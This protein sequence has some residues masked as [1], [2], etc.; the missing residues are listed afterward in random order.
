[1]ICFCKYIKLISILFICQNQEQPEVAKAKAPS[2]AIAD[3]RSLEDL[4][5]GRD[6]ALI[7][8][9]LQREAQEA[10]EARKKEEEEKKKKGK[11]P[12]PV[13]AKPPGADKRLVVK[14]RKPI[15]A[16]ERPIAESPREE[17]EDVDVPAPRFV[18]SSPPLP[19]VAKMMSQG[20]NP[21]DAYK[22]EG[23]DNTQR[24][25]SPPLPGVAKLLAQ[26]INPADEYKEEE[27]EAQKK[28][29]GSGVIPKT[30]PPKAPA[31]QN[32]PKTQTPKSNTNVDFSKLQPGKDDELIRQILQ[33][34]AEAKAAAAK[35]AEEKAKREGK[36]EEA[37]VTGKPPL[38]PG[39]RGN[40]KVRM[41]KRLNKAIAARPPREPK[42][43]TWRSVHVETMPHRRA[44]G[45]QRRNHYLQDDAMPPPMNNKPSKYAAR[46]AEKPR[47][48]KQMHMIQEE[49]EDEED[50]E[51]PYFEPRRTRERTPDFEEDFEPR[52]PREMTP[53]FED[54]F[55]PRRPREM[56]PEFEE[57]FEQRRPGEMT[58]DFEDARPFRAIEDAEPMMPSR[59]EQFEEM[60]PEYFDDA[61]NYPVKEEA[62]PPRF[63]DMRGFQK[64]NKSNNAGVR[65][66]EPKNAKPSKRAPVKEDPARMIPNMR[67][68]NKY[69]ERFMRDEERPRIPAAVPREEDL[70]LPR[71]VST[72]P[73]VPAAAKREARIENEETTA[74]SSEEYQEAGAVGG[75][76]APEPKQQNEK[77]KETAKSTETKTKEETTDENDKAK[78][79]ANETEKVSLALTKTFKNL[80]TSLQDDGADLVIKIETSRRKKLEP[81]SKPVPLSAMKPSVRT[82]NKPFWSKIPVLKNQKPPPKPQAAKSAEEKKTEESSSAKKPVATQSAA[83]NRKDNTAKKPAKPA[84]QQS[85]LSLPPIPTSMV[86]QQEPPEWTSSPKLPEFKSD[87]RLPDFNFK[88]LP[89]KKFTYDAKSKIGSRR[90]KDKEGFLPP[91]RK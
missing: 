57:N 29:A 67:N 13:T 5:P 31:A 37:P 50:F 78:E 46:K 65:P 81:M 24:S 41:T 32:K 71:F 59:E 23:G 53:D 88:K 91:I 21:A 10:A 45:Q 55:E 61:P 54:D 60:A 16:P 38:P 6:D 52:R 84:P 70:Q 14:M 75:A 26:G 39:A 89:G 7:R 86:G 58:P 33:E 83:E 20:I 8:E 76:A 18:S 72:S 44:E 73:P 3:G 80:I 56:T 77:A 43:K 40:L 90:S 28:G 19:T 2:A 66:K 35:E 64:M 69:S 36:K 48:V 51:T 79:T 85:R 42:A 68:N 1:M 12:R 34:E 62:F 30:K 11:Q 74:P 15:K 9:L 27:V 25:S 4:V 49:F 17:A 63:N 87:K 47:K 82:D 22:E